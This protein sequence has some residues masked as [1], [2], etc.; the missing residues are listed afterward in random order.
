MLIYGSK[1]KLIHFP[2][3]DG[4]KDIQ[5]VNADYYANGGMTAQADGENTGIRTLNA[6]EVNAYVNCWA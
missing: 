5:L 1:E 2:Y 4:L 3:C 6:D